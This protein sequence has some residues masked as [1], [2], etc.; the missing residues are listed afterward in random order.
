ML[1][2]DDVYG[3]DQRLEAALNSR[4]PR[5]PAAVETEAGDPES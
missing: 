5:P 1:F 4:R 3:H 2:F